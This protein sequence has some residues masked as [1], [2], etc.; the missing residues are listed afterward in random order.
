MGAP[1]CQTTFFIEHKWM[2]VDGW[3]K[4]HE[5]MPRFSNGL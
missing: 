3:N 2:P 4:D 5:E 1:K